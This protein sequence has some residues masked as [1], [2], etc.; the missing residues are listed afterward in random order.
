MSNSAFNL[1]S[2]LRLIFPPKNDDDKKCWFILPSQ[3]KSGKKLDLLKSE[4]NSKQ[5]QGKKIWL[6]ILQSFS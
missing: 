3:L 6:E 1:K 5:S 4:F 2:S